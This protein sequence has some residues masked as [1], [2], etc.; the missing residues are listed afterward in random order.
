MNKYQISLIA[1]IVLLCVVFVLYLLFFDTSGIKYEKEKFV[2]VATGTVDLVKDCYNEDIIIRIG[3]SEGQLNKL[4]DA[5][6][7]YR[8]PNNTPVI[9][10]WLPTDK[11]FTIGYVKNWIGKTKYF[12]VCE[13]G[14]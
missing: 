8:P 11:K 3:D 1:G 2:P 12:L 9:T 5:H 7:L 6:F 14:Q 4:G 10:E 13:N